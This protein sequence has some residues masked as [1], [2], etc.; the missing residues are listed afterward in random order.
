MAS[1]ALPPLVARA[2]DLAKELDFAGSC[3]AEVGRLLRALATSRRVAEIG[4]GVGV[5][6]AWIADTAGELVTTETDPRLAAAAADLLGECSNVRVLVGDGLELL[7]PLAP[8]ELVFFDG[9]EKQRPF[10]VA[11]R[12]LGLVQPGGLFVLDDLTPGRPGP[13]PV[14]AFWLRDPRVTAVEVLTTPQTAAIVAAKR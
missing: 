14:R 10:E 7:P 2:Y 11:D 6:A 4:T 8:F 9:S 5:G 3:T 1:A 12:V 13:D